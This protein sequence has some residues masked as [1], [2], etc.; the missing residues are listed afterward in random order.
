MRLLT[1]CLLACAILLSGC[2]VPLSTGLGSLPAPLNST[3]ADETALTAGWSAY[4]A[5]VLAVQLGIAAGKLERGSPK[6]LKAL[7]L[8]DSIERTLDLATAA[9]K[10][11]S[12]KT[13]DDL[14]VQASTLQKL[15]LALVKSEN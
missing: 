9:R 12:A 15:A 1:T 14:I 7:E 8:M 11:G 10:A 5:L 3:K 13:F 6:A 2:A 4:D